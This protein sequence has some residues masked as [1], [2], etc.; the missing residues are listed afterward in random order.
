M[1][2]GPL[3]IPSLLRQKMEENLKGYGPVQPLVGNDWYLSEDEPFPGSFEWYTRRE[4]TDPKQDESVVQNS[5]RDVPSELT[6]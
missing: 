3:I 1:Y 2:P 6:S 4:K 5:I